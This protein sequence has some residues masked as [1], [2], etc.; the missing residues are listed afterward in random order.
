MCQTSSERE[1]LQVGGDRTR[2]T[3]SIVYKSI[4]IASRVSPCSALNSATPRLWVDG[5]PTCA[6]QHLHWMSY[7]TKPQEEPEHGVKGC[8]HSSYT[9]SIHR[10]PR[11]SLTSMQ[12]PGRAHAFSPSNLNTS[13][14]S[15]GAHMPTKKRRAAWYTHQPPG[16]LPAA[17]SRAL[18][19]ALLHL[20]RQSPPPAGLL[21][22]RDLR[23]VRIKVVPSILEC[24][25]E[26]MQRRVVVDRVVG[27]VCACEGGE[28]AGPGVGVEGPVLCLRLGLELR[29]RTVR[30]HKRSRS[31]AGGP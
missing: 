7:R 30:M 10:S 2:A 14:R 12:R 21:V 19:E 17:A 25:D 5:E 26:Q 23:H 1:R 29:S 4:V 31:R 20:V 11:A 6:A 9:S 15:C 3:T 27:D 18:H 13:S 28:H 8:V 16:L 22:L 24:R